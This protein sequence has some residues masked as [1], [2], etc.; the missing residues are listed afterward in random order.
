M[1]NY[2]IRA[3]GFDYDGTV[4]HSYLHGM[5][6]I[7][8]LGA[9]HDL[10]FTDETERLIK[11]HWGVPGSELL[12]LS[13]G[14]TL[15]H[16]E[17]VYEDWLVLEKKSPVPLIRGA[18]KSLEMLHGAGIKC[19]LIT[20][21]TRNSLDASL[22]RNQLLASF[23][24]TV[25]KDDTTAHKPDP[26]VFA[27]WLKKLWEEFSIAPHQVAYVGDGGVDV[28]A[29][30]GAGMIAIAV[31]TGPKH[32]LKARKPTAKFPNIAHVGPWILKQPYPVRM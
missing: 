2:D 11:E 9:L 25:A 20:S 31:E 4:V 15:Q 24:H 26:R 10:P 32:Q 29:A 13:F 12:A 30:L 5:R 8:T 1:H 14:I 18:R 21:R 28:D 6:Y 7:R 27:C 22:T 19:G 23:I 17:L 16:A 3:V